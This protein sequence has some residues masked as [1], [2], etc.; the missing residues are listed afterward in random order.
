MRELHLKNGVSLAVLML[1][2]A[3]SVLGLSHDPVL[4]GVVAVGGPLVGATVTV[5]DANGMRRSALTDAGGH[6][7]IAADG[8]TAPVVMS[9]VE[10]G[11]SNC[12]DS[13]QLW[14]RCMAA[15]VPAF[16]S[17]GETRANINVL[18]DKIASDVAQGLKFKGPQGLV[19]SGSAKGVTPAAV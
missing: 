3:C 8:L 12:S 9:A 16:A 13:A 2:G 18:T 19:D 7:H 10:A 1:T 17:S 6:Y 14:S 5:E 15:V 11:N 4:S